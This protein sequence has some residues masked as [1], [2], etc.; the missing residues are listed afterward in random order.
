M[1]YAYYSLCESNGLVE[2]ASTS[3]VKYVR[4]VI[5]CFL[6][7]KRLRSTSDAN[8]IIKNTSHSHWNCGLHVADCQLIIRVP[9]YPRRR[10][11]IYMH[12]PPVS[13]SIIDLQ[14]NESKQ[15]ETSWIDQDQLEDR[16]KGQLVF[17]PIS[18]WAWM[19]TSKILSQHT[20]ILQST[21]YVP[22]FNIRITH[23]S[24]YRYKINSA[25]LLSLDDDKP[26]IGEAKTWRWGCS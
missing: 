10:R 1:Q 26:S 2:P 15:Y 25:N 3:V 20:V 11:V 22:T 9:P 12:R 17:F 13:G 18:Y 24:L 23:L 16:I 21:W 7:S 8:C 5:D 19:R 14:F 6:R 4:I